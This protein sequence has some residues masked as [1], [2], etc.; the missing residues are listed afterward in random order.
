MHAEAGTKLGDHQVF[1]MC[2]SR[3]VAGWDSGSGRADIALLAEKD[4]VLLEDR[5]AVG[6]LRF[7]EDHGTVAVG[8]ECGVIKSERR[9]VYL[10]V[11][12][13]KDE[14]LCRLARSFHLRGGGAEKASALEIV[15]GAHQL[16]VTI[17]DC[18]HFVQGTDAHSTGPTG[19]CPQFG[20][21][22]SGAVVIGLTLGISD[23][24]G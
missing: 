22:R 4:A 23:A 7:L 14:R 9:E 11:V 6:D 19:G 18:V 20:H 1:A 13:E 15:E 3:T 12:V 16:I 17:D 21:E 8:E 2:P 5:S 10:I 24:T